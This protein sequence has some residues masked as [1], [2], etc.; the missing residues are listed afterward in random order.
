MRGGRNLVA[1]NPCTPE[2]V[3]S[4]VNTI[5]GTTVGWVVDQGILESGRIKLHVTWC[6]VRTR[7]SALLTVVCY[8]RQW[9]RATEYHNCLTR[10]TRSNISTYAIFS[11]CAESEL[12]Q[13]I[14]GLHCPMSFGAFHLSAGHRSHSRSG[15]LKNILK[16]LNACRQSRSHS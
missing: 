12:G 4:T 16:L 15:H 8:N 5:V 1:S 13:L 10:I 6:L 2:G 7:D 14:K 11:A 9:V 3:N